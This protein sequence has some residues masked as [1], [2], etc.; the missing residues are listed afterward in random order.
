MKIEATNTTLLHKMYFC[1]NPSPSPKSE[2]KVK[3]QTSE[4]LECLYSDVS[5][6]QLKISKFSFKILF[7]I[8]TKSSLTLVQY[9]KSNHLIKS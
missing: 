3:C 7:M 8:V 9:C 6:T 1:H 2:S 5:P 4:D